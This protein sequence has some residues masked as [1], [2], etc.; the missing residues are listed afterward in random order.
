MIEKE[1]IRS[2]YRRQEV[3][4]SPAKTGSPIRQIC[5]LLTEVS[6]RRAARVDTLDQ[7][8]D[9]SQH[10][11]TSIT[12]RKPWSATRAEAS[13]M[14]VKA[15]FLCVKVIVGHACRG[16]GPNRQHLLV[17]HPVGRSEC[18]TTINLSFATRI[19]TSKHKANQSNLGRKQ[20]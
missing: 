15:P 17:Q 11:Q 9:N 5:Q 1:P 19:E 10:G 3:T 8:A 2:K 18:V 6:A 16:L 20:P 13:M 4:P 12:V 7:R 14:R